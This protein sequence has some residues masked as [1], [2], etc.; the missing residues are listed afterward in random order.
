MWHWKNISALKLHLLAR[1]VGT[2][3]MDKLTWPE[4][5][6]TPK[7][8][9]SV[10]LTR[11]GRQEKVSGRGQVEAMLGDLDPTSSSS[12]NASF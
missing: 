4:E 10:F 1:G 6:L 2:K 8:T 5:G 9:D 3:R 7:G 11:M 12:L